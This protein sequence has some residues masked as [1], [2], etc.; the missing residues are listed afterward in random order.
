M[1]VII[2]CKTTAKG[3]QSYYLIYGGMQ[4]F[5]FSMAYRRSNRAYYGA[6][7]TV[8]DVIKAC[9]NHSTS[10]RMASERIIRCIKDI[11]KVFEISVLDRSEKSRRPRRKEPRNRDRLRR[12]TESYYYDEG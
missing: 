7:R 8:W 3:V 11:E 6:G 9:K 4:Y 5:L 12:E 1:K 10:V 2:I